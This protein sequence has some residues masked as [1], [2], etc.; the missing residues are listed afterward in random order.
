[1]GVLVYIIR[2]FC[3][4]TRQWQFKKGIELCIHRKEIVSVRDIH[5]EKPHPDNYI[6]YQ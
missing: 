4:W 2:R 5:Y 3:A 6:E 1:M